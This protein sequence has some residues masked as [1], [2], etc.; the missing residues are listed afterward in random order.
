MQI[1]LPSKVSIIIP[2]HNEEGVLENQ[3]SLIN[4][5]IKSVVKNFEIILVENESKDKSKEIIIEFAR[6]K[7]EI[8]PVIF[9]YADYGGALREGIIKSSGEIVHICQIDFF[10]LSFFQ[11]SLTKLDDET[12]FIIASRNRF[13]WD[14]RP[15]QRKI[16]TFGLNFLLKVFFGFK[17][18]DTHGLK[19]FYRKSVIGFV[20]E[21]R[22]RRGM[23]DTEFTLR[24]QYS[25]L[26]ILEMPVKAFEI[27]AKRN[28][29]FQ[30]IFRNIIDLIVMKR[31]FIKEKKNATK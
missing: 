18:T 4:E 9:P 11:N 10:H 12:P 5:G 16:L 1:K 15:L 8:I 2:I 20:K 14:N 27:R 19:T 13:G 26:N 7:P 21:C 23:F 22:M 24:S 25:G 29:Y 30:K 31:I 6:E 3:L 28:T 17:G